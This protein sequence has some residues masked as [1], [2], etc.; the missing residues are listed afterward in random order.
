MSVFSPALDDVRGSYIYLLNYAPAP[1]QEGAERIGGMGGTPPQNR[2]TMISMGYETPPHHRKAHHRT[3]NIN[4]LAGTAAD[5]RSVI[6][7]ALPRSLSAP[8]R[9]RFCG[10]GRRVGRIG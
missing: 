8:L 6:G 9:G 7:A 1:L 3:R 4:R 5:R 2:R 10:V